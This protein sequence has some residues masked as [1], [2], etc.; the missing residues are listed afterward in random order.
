MDSLRN[1][2]L[3]HMDIVRVCEP[4]DPNMIAA[5]A[6]YNLLNEMGL[7]K[8]NVREEIHTLRM[9]IEAMLP[10]I[11]EIVLHIWEYLLTPAQHESFTAST[12]RVNNISRVQGDSIERMN[13]IVVNQ[14]NNDST[15]LEI[16]IFA[17]TEKFHDRDDVEVLIF[18]PGS[19]FFLKNI[20]SIDS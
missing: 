14:I 2:F 8:Y 3:N 6:R 19:T 18:T 1:Y 5:W 13:R 10:I 11:D 20:Y 16:S 9:N 17:G 7:L 15:P 4:R 12:S